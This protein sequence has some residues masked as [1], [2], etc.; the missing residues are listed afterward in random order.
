M[1]E[2]IQT[3]EILT[4]TRAITRACDEMMPRKRRRKMRNEVYWWTEKISS[5]R[6]DC[7]LI[8]RQNV[9][10]NRKQEGQGRLGE[11]QYTPGISGRRKELREAIKR[12]KTGRWKE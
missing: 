2:I 4:F 7:I 11:N 6:Y 5:L 9:R 1:E 3:Q 8:S 12:S 10:E